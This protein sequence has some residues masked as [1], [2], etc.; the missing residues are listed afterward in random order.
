[1]SLVLFARKA[2][3]ELR[4]VRDGVKARAGVEVRAAVGQAVAH[5]L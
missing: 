5:P 1:M 3:L 2:G 4:H